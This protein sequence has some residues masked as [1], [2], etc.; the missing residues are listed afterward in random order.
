MTR[1]RGFKIVEYH[2]NFAENYQVFVAE[3]R[4]NF[5]DQSL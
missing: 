5:L 1:I 2:F 3:K 4:V